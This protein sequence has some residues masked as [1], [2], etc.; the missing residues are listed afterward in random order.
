MKYHIQ[1]HI[2]DDNARD[3]LSSPPR[4]AQIELDEKHLQAAGLVETLSGHK[5]RLDTLA[6]SLILEKLFSKL[7]K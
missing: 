6:A 2:Y 1:L 4:Y 3:L 5:H 7:Q